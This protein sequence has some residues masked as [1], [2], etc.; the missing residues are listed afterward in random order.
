MILREK[1]LFVF[2]LLLTLG[3]IKHVEEME[4]LCDLSV[5]GLE[6]LIDYQDYPV[7]AAELA[8]KARRSLGIGYIGLAHYLAKHGVKYDSQE[9]WDL[10]HELT[11]AFQYYLIKSSNTIAIEKGPAQ[12][13]IAP[14]IIKVSFRL[15]HIRRM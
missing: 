7:V 3:K 1:L 6:E 10:V 13:I 2:F 15:I 5:R 11:E 8:T 4:E 14:S 9:A 12:T